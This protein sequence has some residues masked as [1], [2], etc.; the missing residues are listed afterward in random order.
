MKTTR[1]TLTMVLGLVGSLMAVEA[2]AGGHGFHSAGSSGGSSHSA[3]Y[4]SHQGR[5]NN[6][7]AKPAN[8]HPTGQKSVFAANKNGSTNHVNKSEQFSKPN[9]NKTQTSTSKSNAN[10]K[11]SQFDHHKSG[12]KDWFPSKYGWDHCGFGWGGCWDQGCRW[13]PC[14]Y[15]CYTP[16]YFTTCYNVCSEYCVPESYSYSPAGPAVA[17]GP[18]VVPSPF[19]LTGPSGPTDPSI[20]A[21]PS[22]P[23]GPVAAT[24][25]VRIVNPAETQTSLSF[26]VNGEN[27]TLEAGKS[28]EL[29]VADKAV[30]EFDRGTGND[31]G[32]Y[33]LDEGVYRF[34][35]TPQGWE[36]HHSNGTPVTDAVA[37]N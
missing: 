4:S 32:R 20:P 27:H 11:F 35:S 10:K 36:L 3:N 30:I 22:G 29:G 37:A 24:K 19:D 26:S 2:K 34:T 8:Y 23:G 15:G 25:T 1:I 5:I 13:W 6:S 12:K 21:G 18:S 7:A 31:V 16:C 14:S 9:F 28:E 33:S 17:T